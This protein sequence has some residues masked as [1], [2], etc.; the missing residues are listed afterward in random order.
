MPNLGSYPAGNRAGLVWSRPTRHDL[1]QVPRMS[2]AILL[3]A[4][5]PRG[6][7]AQVQPDEGT[8]LYAGANI[9]QFFESWE[10]YSGSVGIWAVVVGYDF[11]PSWGIRGEF[12]PRLEMCDRDAVVIINGV[13][14]QGYCHRHGGLINRSAVRHLPRRPYLLFGPIHAGVGLEIPLGRR[15]SASAEID[16]LYGFSAAAAWPKAALTTRF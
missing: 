11:N 12:G 1:L 4:L 5:V 13:T 16:L 8:G 7:L 3:N 15:L 10:G 6:T 2:L 14:T 9:G